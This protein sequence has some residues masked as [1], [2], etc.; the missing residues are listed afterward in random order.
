MTDSPVN[1]RHLVERVSIVTG[2]G[3][4][5][6][7]AIARRLAQC[8]SAVV[9]MDETEDAPG[10]FG[11]SKGIESV[12]E[13]IR[14]FGV[15]CLPFI[16]DLRDPSVCREVAC[17]AQSRFGRIDILVNN[18]GGDI[19]ATGEKPDPNDLFIDETNFEAVI[20]RNL[21]TV[22]NMCRAVVPLM[23]KAGSGRIVNI[24]SVAAFIATGKE[25]A[26]SVAKAGV[27]HLTRCLAAF[28]KKDGITVNAVAPGNTLSG[29]FLATLQS[30]GLTEKDLLPQGPLMRF[31]YP[32]DIASAVEFFVS[33]LGSYITGQVLIVDGGTFSLQ[34]CYP[35]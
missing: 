2:S 9:V 24:A 7:K 11:E 16:G 30:R 27:V 8:G 14:Q 6:G 26:Y 23:Q 21:I 13:E 35:Q 28:L 20:G 25:I 34:T 3:R 4:G 5:I 22:W 12:A 33:D 29:R 31:A 19:G 18:A 17:L 10:K 15:P 1:G 32:E